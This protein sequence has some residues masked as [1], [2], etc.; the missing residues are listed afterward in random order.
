MK[1]L[2]TYEKTYEII[3]EDEPQVG[4]WVICSVLSIDAI[5]WTEL[6]D[7]LNTNIGKYAENDGTGF[8][9]YIIRYKNVPNKLNNENFNGDMFRY[10]HRREIVRFSKNKEDLEIYID[11][12]KYN[13]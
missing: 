5:N 7:F 9:P 2:K 12:N 10:V 4:D 6:N 13:L 11:A 1:H 3:E 8:K